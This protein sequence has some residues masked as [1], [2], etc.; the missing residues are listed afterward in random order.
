PDFIPYL[1][2][3]GTSVFSV[4]AT[5]VESVEPSFPLSLF[6]HKTKIRFAKTKDN[7]INFFINKILK[8]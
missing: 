1:A 7:K 6:E 2:P 3:C 8:F 4:V 5:C